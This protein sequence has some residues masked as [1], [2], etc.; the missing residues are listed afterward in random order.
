MADH[1]VIRSKECIEAARQRGWQIIVDKKP[2]GSVDGE[3]T[4]ECERVSHHL[5]WQ[6]IKIRNSVDRALSSDILHDAGG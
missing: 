1:V 6:V 4:L 5:G 3:S 2:Q